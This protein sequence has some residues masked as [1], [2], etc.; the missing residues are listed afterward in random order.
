LSHP[1]NLGE[2]LSI[3]E[4]SFSNDELYMIGT[5]KSNKRKTRIVAIVAGTSADTLILVLQKNWKKVERK[6]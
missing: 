3:D 1:Q 4:T 6:I 5:I 2:D